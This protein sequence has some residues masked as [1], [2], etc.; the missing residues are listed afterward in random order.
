MSL[1]FP[2]TKAARRS[3]ISGMSNMAGLIHKLV[4]PRK[5]VPSRAT[6]Q[7]RFD[8]FL[9]TKAEAQMGT[10]DTAVLRETNATVVWKVRIL[11]L[12]DSCG[13]Y[14]AKFPA[15]LFGDGGPQILDFGM[16]F[17]DEYHESDFRNAR[18]PG[19]AKKLGVEGQDPCGFFCVPG[20]RGFPVDHRPYPIELTYGVEISQKLIAREQV[21]FNL[22]LKVLLWIGNAD[23]V[24]AGE[25]L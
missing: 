13:H 25:K 19:I 4:Q 2:S 15:L 23:A 1:I 22:D 9:V 3:S 8:E 24:V 11:D 10:A 20:R 14:I 12:V 16:V 18:E 21:A 7:I 17:T 5:V 6:S